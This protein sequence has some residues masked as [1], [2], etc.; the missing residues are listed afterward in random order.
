VRGDPYPE[1]FTVEG[2]QPGEVPAVRLTYRLG[3]P[4]IEEML[5]RMATIHSEVTVA[6]AVAVGGG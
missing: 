3:Q 2:M 5:H 6:V 1:S 4:G